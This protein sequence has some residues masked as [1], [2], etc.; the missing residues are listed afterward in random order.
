[1][2]TSRIIL[3]DIVKEEEQVL[4][5]RQ[6]K[7]AKM[8]SQT[9]IVLSLGGLLA[10]LLSIIISILVIRMVVEPIV[11]VTNTFKEISDGD[12]DLDVRLKTSFL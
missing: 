2:D 10:T 4:V 5:E 3:D 11:T 1:M 6:N 7:L 8:E 9:A 12:V